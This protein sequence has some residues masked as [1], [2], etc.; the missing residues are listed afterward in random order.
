[1]LLKSIGTTIGIVVPLTSW[2]LSFKLPTKP[3]APPPQN[4]T[5]LEQY[6][7]NQFSQAFQQC[8]QDANKDDVMAQYLVAMMYKR[9]KG[10]ATNQ[11]EAV[12][13]F[14]K[15]AMNGNAAAQLKLGKI[16]SQGGLMPP[17]YDKAFQ[18]FTMAANQNDAEAQFLLALCYLNGLGVK[19][20]LQAA[21]QWYSKAQKNDLENASVL[22]FSQEHA[23]FKLNDWP[24]HQEYKTASLLKQQKTEEAQQES[25]VWLKLAAEKGH[26][27]AQYEVGITY[28]QGLITDQDDAK[29]LSWLE[30]AA[31]HDHQ[32]AQSYLSW[33]AALGLGKS[34][35]LYDAIHWFKLAYGIT[36]DSTSQLAFSKE[37]LSPLEIQKKQYEKGIALIEGHAEE[38]HF[39][40]GFSLIE[41]SAKMN[42]AP[43]QLYL[44]TLYRDGEKVAKN[45]GLAAKYFEK[46]AK[47]GS[48][49]AQYALG[50]IYFNG[51]GVEKN[52]SK[53]YLWFDQA[54]KQGDPRAISAK[55]FVGS[56]LSK[57]TVEPKHLSPRLA[58]S[59]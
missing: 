30:S 48:K 40:Q 5:C 13:W 12:N 54:G 36:S 45:A 55:Q 10:T 58:H 25:F 8:L 23:P 41:Q 11:Q 20:D 34:Q 51:E 6:Q 53:A 7:Q 49:D 50:W 57:T 59:K 27:Q 44:A 38:P 3:S 2:G 43:A 47:N 9:G 24:G 4:L 16:L 17:D 32:A 22:S 19:K 21:E 52:P 28:A 35:N 26:P 39:E 29:A 15:A 33:M 37:Q 46:A 18:F 42:F 31:S 1:M 56:Q 14:T